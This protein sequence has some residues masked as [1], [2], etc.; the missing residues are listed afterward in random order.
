MERSIP[1]DIRPDHSHTIQVHNPAT[2]EEIGTVPY[3]DAGVVDTAV[4]AASAG[5]EVWAARD[6]ADRG[7]VLYHAA[8]LIR[9][10]QEELARL[11][12]T[13]QGKPLKESKNEIAGFSRVLEYYASIAGGL[14]GDYGHSSLYGHALVSRHP[15]GVCGAI[16]PWN[17]PALIMAW[18]VGPALAAGNAIIVKPAS[19]APLTCIRLASVLVSAGVPE[20]VLQVITG[21]GGVVGEAMAAHPGIRALSFTGGTETGRRVASLAAPHFKKITLEL[22][23]SDPMIVCSDADL[24]EAAR[25]A[26]AGRFYNCGQTCTAVKRLFVDEKI[27][28]AFIRKTAEIIRSLRIGSGLSPGV[29]MGPM[30]SDFQRKQLID[31]VSRTIDGGFGRLQA[32]GACPQ[33]PGLTGSFYEPTLITGLTPGA[34]VLEEEV[35]GPVLPVM[36]FSTIDEAFDEA[37]LTRYGLGASVW[38][39]DTRIVSRAIRELQAGIVWINQHLKI[40]PEVPFGGTKDSGIGRENGRYALDHYLE[41]KTILIKP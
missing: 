9:S 8:D 36:P 38:T 26:V 18:K 10:R 5:W 27:E 32:G 33:G 22:G 35:F 4:N 31:Q 37:N 12:T 19:T 23:G 14:R 20:A 17:M 40:P 28:E 16:I 24:T 3:G 7:K 6:P 15:L 25:G 2:G 11:L 13:E 30:H 1:A 39:H 34:P 41:E 21:P 29:D